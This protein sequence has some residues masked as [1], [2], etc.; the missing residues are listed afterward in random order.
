MATA[1]AAAFCGDTIPTFDSQTES[2]KAGENKKE[3]IS[4]F[5]ADFAKLVET[6][7]AKWNIPGVALAVVDGEETFAEVFLE[8][9]Y[10]K[11]KPNF[12]NRDTASPPY[13]MCLSNPQL[14][15]AQEVQQSHLPPPQLHC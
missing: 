6:T 14:S 5:D 8:N 7:L 2:E 3:K 4:P 15:S 1:V 9:S 12:V 13:Q 10:G 11:D